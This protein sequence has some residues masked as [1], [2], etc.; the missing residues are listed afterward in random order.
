MKTSSALKILLGVAAC[1]GASLSHAVQ[2]NGPDQF[3]NT[4]TANIVI[5]QDW[6]TPSP[7][8]AFLQHIDLTYDNPA[9]N[10]HSHT[11]DVDANNDGPTWVKDF[12]DCGLEPTSVEGDFEIGFTVTYDWGNC[13][14]PADSNLAADTYTG[15]Y[16]G[17]NWPPAPPP[18]YTGNDPRWDCAQLVVVTDPL[19]NPTDITLTTEDVG[20][21]FIY[22]LL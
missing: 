2:F 3:S 22:D 17:V 8:L 1:A 16:D 11:W 19:F 18:P 7:C 9:I 20:N 5:D 6:Q 12:A 21:V 13:S 10:E 15:S 14:S 4:A